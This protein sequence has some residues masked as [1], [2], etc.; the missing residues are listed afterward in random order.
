MK[1]KNENVRVQ[2]SNDSRERELLS[3]LFCLAFLIHHI[4][5]VFRFQH[6]SVFS[7][8]RSSEDWNESKFATNEQIEMMSSRKRE[9]RST[10]SNVAK[11]VTLKYNSVCHFS[12]SEM[13]ICVLSFILHA[14]EL[15]KRPKWRI[16]KSVNATSK[17]NGIWFLSSECDVCGNGCCCFFARRPVSFCVWAINFALCVSPLS[18][19][20]HLLRAHLCTCVAALRNN[21]NTQ[22]A[23]LS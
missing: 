21:G 7:F 22:A 12:A 3:F 18:R 8:F 17:T 16:A 20:V 23:D 5:I 9:I 15:P 6:N 14:I 1:M 19:K 10:I 4:S 13:P 2:M 11:R